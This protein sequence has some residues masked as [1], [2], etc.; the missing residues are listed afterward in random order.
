MKKKI[1]DNRF[2][3]VPDYSETVRTVRK[4]S[5]AVRMSDRSGSWRG[6]KCR[7]DPRHCSNQRGSREDIVLTTLFIAVAS[8]AAIIVSLRS[9]G[10]TNFNF[11]VFPRK[12]IF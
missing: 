4:C 6:N 5:T 9:S 12:I 11:F 10:R 3:R 2:A 7:C 8:T 1:P